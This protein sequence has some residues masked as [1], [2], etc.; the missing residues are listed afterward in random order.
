MAISFLFYFFQSELVRG[1]I[2]YHIGTRT[3]LLSLLLCCVALAHLFSS[4]KSP[5]FWCWRLT[6]FIHQSEIKLMRNDLPTPLRENVLSQ[7]LKQ[8]QLCYPPFLKKKLFNSSY[9]GIHFSYKGE[10]G[11]KHDSYKFARKKCRM[12]SLSL[13]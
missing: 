2:F 5:Y 13:Q 10:F 6:L 12:N 7:S 9:L 3:F 11:L 8:N 1:S 4:L